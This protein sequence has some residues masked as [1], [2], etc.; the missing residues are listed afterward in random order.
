MQDHRDSLLP[1][2]PLPTPRFPAVLPPSL[3]PLQR[4]TSISSSAAHHPTFSLLLLPPTNKKTP[5]P[6]VLL[7]GFWGKGG[8][9]T[10]TAQAGQGDR[11]VEVI[12]ARRQII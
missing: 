8:Y 11:R 12:C 3:A 7:T 10:Q 5:S 4:H 9:A 6:G 2:P 1:F